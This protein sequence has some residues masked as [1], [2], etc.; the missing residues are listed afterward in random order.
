MIFQVAAFN[1]TTLLYFLENLSPE[2]LFYIPK[3][4]KNNIIWNLGHILITEQML[5]YGLSDLD[6]T[7][8]K[9]F[10]KLYGKGSFPSNKVSKEAVEEIKTQLIPAINQT[11][12]DYKKDVF[13][14]YN[15]YPTSTG[16]TLKNIDDALQFNVLHEG[17]HL[18]I[19][20]AIKKL[21]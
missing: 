8:D 13:K 17:I 18:G 21:V 20:L 6:L 16:I 7:V 5:T 9:K 3:G 11:E 14:N 2:Q 1:R 15:E 12:K 19:I 10:I 4:F